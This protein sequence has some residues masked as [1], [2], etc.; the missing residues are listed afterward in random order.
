MPPTLEIVEPIV[1]SPPVAQTKESKEVGLQRYFD[2]ESASVLLTK[3]WLRLERGIRFQKFRA[4]AE[5]YPGLRAEE[6]ENLF[7]MLAKANDAKLLNTKQQIVYENGI[8][9][10]VKG[11]KIIHTGDPSVPAV[12]KIEIVR[13]TKKNSAD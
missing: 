4:F 11:L 1:L 13:P 5:S 9:T 10:A 7:R 8:I 12:F 2:A 3:P 6:R